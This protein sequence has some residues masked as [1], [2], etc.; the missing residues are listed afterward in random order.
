MPPEDGAASRVR[1]PDSALRAGLSVSKTGQGGGLGRR[2]VLSLGD[3]YLGRTDCVQGV[4]RLHWLSFPSHC[5]NAP[6]TSPQ[7]TQSTALNLSLDKHPPVLYSS[8]KVWLTVPPLRLPFSPP[9]RVYPRSSRL[10]SRLFTTNI[11][12]PRSS[13]FVFMLLQIPFFATPFLSHLYKT[14][15][16][17]GGNHESSIKSPRRCRALSTARGNTGVSLQEIPV[18]AYRHPLAT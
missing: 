1:T 12:H 13:S 9:P 2:Q 10:R 17:F 5:G 14:L 15:C 6:H 11:P 3:P 4:P 18:P 8:V 16:V 7:P